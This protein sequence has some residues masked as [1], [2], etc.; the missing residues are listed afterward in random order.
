[1]PMVREGRV[2][3][4]FAL[5]RPQPGPF[6]E[7]EIELVRT[8]ADQALIAIENVRLFNEVQAKTRD[9][10]ESLEHQTAISDILRVISSSPGNVQPVLATVAQHAAQICEAQIV[11]ILTVKDDKF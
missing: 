6:S 11:D 4:V 9:L 1:I 3:G 10:S 5:T 7:R 2:E 8:F